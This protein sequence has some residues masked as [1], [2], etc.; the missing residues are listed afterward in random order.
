MNTV[1]IN[2]VLLLAHS[3]EAA[4]RPRDCP[5]DCA[6]WRCC[7]CR[8]ISAKPRPPRC[9]ISRS[10]ALTCKVISGDSVETVSGI[11]R[12]AGMDNW[13]KCYRHVQGVPKRKFR[14]WRQQ[15]TVFGRRH[16]GAEKTAGEGPAE[17][18]PHRGHDRRR[19]E[20][21]D[22]AERS[23]LRHRHRGRCGRRAQRGPSGA[24]E[25]QL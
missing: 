23:R 25:I 4:C 11:A 24:A 2:R 16:T 5:P 8:T 10:R 6:P 14:T 13:D 22:G 3:D 19:R 12:R 9:A 7:C 18:G 1:R 15:Y 21:R 20:R 17:E